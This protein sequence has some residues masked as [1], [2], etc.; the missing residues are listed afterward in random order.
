[1][2]S[3]ARPS[4]PSSLEST[5]S[6]RVSAS[7][8]ASARRAACCRR[9]RA[10]HAVAMRALTDKANRPPWRKSRCLHAI[11]KQEAARRLR[12]AS[13]SIRMGQAEWISSTHI[14]QGALVPTIHSPEVFITC[15]EGKPSCIAWMDILSQKNGLN[16][17]KEEGTTAL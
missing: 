15:K 1:M 7:A 5:R 17:L 12:K 14:Q 11:S 6:G 3:R 9:H 10:K 16:L 2:S 13:W 8:R 4:S